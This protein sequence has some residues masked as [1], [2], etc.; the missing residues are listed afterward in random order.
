MRKVLD[1][2]PYLVPL[3]ETW[4]GKRCGPAYVD[5]PIPPDH[6]GGVEQ[7]GNPWSCYGV[8]LT[9]WDG[10]RHATR[11]I[12]IQCGGIGGRVTCSPG[13]LLTPPWVV[14]RRQ[15][16]AVKRFRDAGFHVTVD[17]AERHKAGVAAGVVVAQEPERG[18]RMCRRADIWLVVSV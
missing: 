15:K 6:T 11:R 14:G 9:I 10:K 4:Q 7:L 5:D 3:Q 17:R 16:A 1:R 18:R 13:Q 2:P 12:A 8:A